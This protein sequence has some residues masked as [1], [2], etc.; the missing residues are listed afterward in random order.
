[1][2]G[3]SNYSTDVLTTT[4]E[5][6]LSKQPKDAIFQ[7]LAL[8]DVL[9]K[10]AKTKRKGGIKLLEPLMYAKSSSGG[11]YSG[12]DTFDV[13]PQQGL[14]NAEFLWKYYYWSI[15]I[16]GQEEQ[17][18]AG[19]GQ[20]I[21]LLEAK[22]EQ[23]KMSMVDAIGSDLFLDGTGNSSKKVTGLALAVDNAGTYGNI[24]RSSNTWWQSQENGNAVALAVSGANGLRRMFND[25][26]YGKMKR[27]PN[28]IVTTQ[29]G[30]ESYEALMD[31]NMR[32]SNTGEQ[33]VGFAR[34]NLMFRDAPMFWDDYCQD[35]TL[36]ML[37][38]D[39]LKWI[40]NSD[41]DMAPTPFKTPTN[42]D[43]K[44]AQVLWAGNLTCSNC[45]HQGKFT[46]LT[47]A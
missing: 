30:F 31:T 36:Y 7:D 21:D 32:Y 10:R 46:A 16:N 2:P 14:T 34:P 44:V 12:W 4:F 15:T 19:E 22:W 8:L 13:A 45:R 35:A 20:M 39:F 29:E 3:N 40:V 41:R 37:N 17:E 25:C 23:T 33:N 5:V 18:N 24:A 28:L 38:T 47:N 27:T 9:D 26:S 1:M 42:Q 6:F 43:G 11:S